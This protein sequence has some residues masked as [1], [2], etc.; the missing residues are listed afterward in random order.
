M[1]NPL[2][3][4]V[5]NTRPYRETSLLVN[6]Y[7]DTWGRADF[8]VKGIRTVRNRALASL[9]HPLSILDT[10]TYFHAKRELNQLKEYQK[11]HLLENLCSDVRKSSISLFISELLYKTVRESEE[12]RELFGFVT[13]TILDLD[14]AGTELADLH[15][16][17]AV[18][19]CRYLGYAP[20]A[21]SFSADRKYFHIGKACF[22]DTPDLLSGAFD[23]E[24]S[25]LLQ[26][27]LSCPSG[28]IRLLSCS[29]S[30]RHHFL[31]SLMSY[32]SYHLGKTPEIR[33]LDI[34]HQVFL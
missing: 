11:I 16:Y 15:L 27:V 17:F 9:F 12:N 21:E 13:N 4:I 32:Y 3:L 8:L 26:Q 2:T 10:R 30:R 20:D 5:L 14:R 25:L 18:R 28:E 19:L 6:A 22:C 33:S 34:L 29:G 1:I 23:K 7:T 31:N 24:D